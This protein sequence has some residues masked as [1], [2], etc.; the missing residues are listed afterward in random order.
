MSR[1][2]TF[3][4]ILIAAGLIAVF[5]IAAAY[6]VSPAD[7]TRDP[8]AVLAIP[9]YVGLLSNWGVML[10]SAAAAICLFTA[11]TLRRRERSASTWL[12]ASGLITLIL[13]L[14]DMFM[15]HEDVFPNVFGIHEKVVYTIYILA[16]GIFILY[17][18]PEFLKRSYLIF[19]SAILF[20]GISVISDSIGRWLYIP[21]ALEVRSSTWPSF[22]GWSFLR[23]QLEM[24]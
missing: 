12:F 11:W 13:A 20:L 15:L 18:L 14:D 5:G 10:C 24:N 1:V 9:Y 4:L 8:A 6:G 23:R 2:S 21:T 3:A 22:Y 17:F 19:A 16:G 7:L